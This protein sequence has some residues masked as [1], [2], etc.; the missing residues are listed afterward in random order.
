MFE[1]VF[2]SVSTTDRFWFVFAMQ[3]VSG[4]VCTCTCISKVCLTYLQASVSNTETEGLHWTL[5]FIRL[6]EVGHMRDTWS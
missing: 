3:Y 2:M 6:L 5:C 1:I 4:S